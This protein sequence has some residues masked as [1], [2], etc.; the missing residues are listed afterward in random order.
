MLDYAALFAKSWEDKERQALSEDIDRQLNYIKNV[1]SLLKELT[2]QSQLEEDAYVDAN[3]EK[4]EEL[5]EKN[6]KVE[7]QYQSPRN[8]LMK[9]IV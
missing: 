2:E 9:L 6:E 4:F 1:G 8:M 7:I 3:A 5:K